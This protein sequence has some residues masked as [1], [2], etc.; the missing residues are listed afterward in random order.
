MLK[1]QHLSSAA[2]RRLKRDRQKERRKQTG[3]IPEIEEKNVPLAFDENVEIEYIPEPLDLPSEG[4]SKILTKFSLPSL[5]AAKEG[6]EDNNFYS[7]NYAESFEEQDMEEDD[8]NDNT[9]KL[10]KKKLKRQQQMSVAALKQFARH[11]EVVEWEDVTAKE[12]KLLVQLKSVP[13][14]VPIPRHW[15]LKRK[16]LAG[17]RGFVKPPFELPA[18]I[19]DTG[20]TELREAARQED[21]TK[22]IKV[23]AR[24]KMHPKL[25]KISVDY[26]RLYDAFF[27]FQTKPALTGY[28]DL[29]FEGREFELGGSDRASLRKQ[30]PGQFSDELRVPLGLDGPNGHLLPPPWLHNMQRFGPPPSYPHLKIPGLNAPLPEGAQWGYHPGGWGKPPVDQTGVPLALHGLRKSNDPAYTRLLNPIDPNIWGELEPDDLDM[31]DTNEPDEGQ[32]GEQTVDPERAEQLLSAS[33]G[34]KQRT[35]EAPPVFTDISETITPSRRT[36]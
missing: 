24:E 29:Y 3:S 22:R 7:E 30:R 13:N 11:A 19:R 23:K 14:T 20:I 17:K 34:S 2:I 1:K 10:S 5:D 35:E 31:A 21:A 15:T 8:D 6:T 27:K 18:F 25:G 26:E 9:V 16:Y 32:L 33:V 12:P 36:R 4:F 28:G